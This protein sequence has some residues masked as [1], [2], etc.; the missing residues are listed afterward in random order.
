MDCEIEKPPT[1]INPPADNSFSQVIFTNVQ[2]FYPPKTDLH[3]KFHIEGNFNSS[4]KDWIGIFKVGWKTTRDYYTWISARTSVDNTVLFTVYYL[5]SDDDYYQFCYVDLNG[6]VRG[7][8]I[9]FQ[10]TYNPESEDEDILMVAPEREV[11]KLTEEKSVLQGQVSSLEA[12]NQTQAGK[13]QNLQDDLLSATEKIQ[14]LE[15]ENMELTIHAKNHEDELETMNKTIQSLNIDL[16]MQRNQEQK[17]LS[18]MKEIEKLLDNFKEVNKNSETLQ[19]HIQETEKGKLKLESELTLYKGK[20]QKLIA[21]REELKQALEKSAAEKHHLQSE[22]MAKQKLVEDVTCTLTQCREENVKLTAELELQTSMLE[23]EKSANENLKQS[24]HK[25][26][27]KVLSV[28]RMLKQKNEELRSAE[29]TMA[30]LIKEVDVLEGDN[31]NKSIQI[32]T[33]HKTIGNL[34]GEVKQMKDAAKMAAEKAEKD[35]RE[36]LASSEDRMLGLELQLAEQQDASRQQGEEL[37][38]LR[39]TLDV[40][41]M[42]VENLKETHRSDRNTIDELHS[43][44]L[45]RAPSSFMTQ[46]QG[47][48]FG[49]PYEVVSTENTS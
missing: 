42:E 47:L 5:P 37:V 28:E 14:R 2:K 9:P 21:E 41:N 36:Q 8:S 43:H 33:F 17:L 18:E 13:I 12:E 45:G 23:K 4:P 27:N 34:E 6:E 10:F 19:I 32:E 16:Q 7:A 30:T 46:Q 26:F 15:K 35:L 20:E 38:V 11:E 44:L 24:L 40:R 3:C 29:E 1:S 25:E 48:A 39:S 49:N 22:D 31:K